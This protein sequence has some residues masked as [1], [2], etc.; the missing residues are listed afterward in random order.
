[1][2]KYALSFLLLL[3]GIACMVTY[4]IIGSEVAPDGT[5]TEPFGLIPIGYFFLVIGITSGVVLS[6]HSVIKKKKLL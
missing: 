4:R 5:L 3:L 1:M 2:K 6:I